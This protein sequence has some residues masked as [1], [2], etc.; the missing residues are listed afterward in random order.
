MFENSSN[1]NIDSKTSFISTENSS[2]NNQESELENKFNS[3]QEQFNLDENLSQIK[4]K[5]ISKELSLGNNNRNKLIMK[6]RLNAKTNLENNLSLDK[7]LKIP[8]ETYDNLNNEEIRISD[9]SKIINLFHSKNI[10]EKFKGLIG[11]R[12][13]LSLDNSPTSEIIDLKVVPELINLLDN[14]L[15]EF[16]YEAIWC[17]C[18][19]AGGTSEQSN[20]ILISGG[21]NSILN[22]LDC[23]VDDIKANTIWLIA[24]LINDSMKT[25]DTLI[26]YKFLDKILTILAS[27][28]NEN[29]INLS[30]WA[31]SNFFRIK[32]IPNFEISNKTFNV[33][34]RAVLR[35]NNEK[36]DFLLD[37]GVFLSI[38]TKNYSQFI[39][40]IIDIGL[41]QKIIK[42][43]DIKN[44]NILI[45]FLRVVGNIASSENAN[46]TQ[47]LIDLGIL[48][49]LKYTLFNESLSIRAESCFILSNIAA[50]T[51]KQIEILIEQNFLQIMY[52]IFKNDDKKVKKEALMCIA[53]MT[54]VENENYMK[55]LIEDNI[56]MIDAELL[57]SDNSTFIII[58]LE[59]LANLL[60]FGDKKGQIKEF[61]NE[62]EKLGIIDTLEKL[63]MHESQIIYEKTLQIF[64]AYFELAD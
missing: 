4:E 25:R 38:L 49:K 51:Q 5:A 36:D 53:N 64:D 27:T 61:Q 2:K 41:L 26:Q 34:S 29:L 3:R 48:D 44:R 17:L 57:Q 22:M 24:N 15:Y 21:L 52:K 47:K 35:N 50:G 56:F 37:V 58:G 33:V 42:Y 55:K 23:P 43:L 12:K 9:F 28:N 39:Q 32:P 30:I 13:L 18:N 46:Q 16:K 54:T 11:L 6:K 60:A 19:I 8:K 10:D 7:V 45:N 20:S 40:E 63:Q 59:M 62:C 1:I 31:I 14:P